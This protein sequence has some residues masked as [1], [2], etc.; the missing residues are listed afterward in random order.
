MR[1]LLTRVGLAGVALFLF[2]GRVPA[3]LLVSGSVLTAAGQRPE[4]AI[5]ELFPILS[6]FELG[7]LRLQGME[8][9]E[10]TAIGRPTRE[11]RFQ[12]EAPRSGLYRLV[13][14]MPDSMPVQIGPIALVEDLEL[15]PVAPP[16]DIGVRL[17]VVDAEGLPVA[18]ARA[19]SSGDESAENGWRLDFRLGRTGS[20]GHLT[21]PRRP[22]EK[23]SLSV[24]APAWGE[25]RLNSFAGGQVRMPPAGAL[26]RLRVVSENGAPVPGILLR[27]GVHGWPVGLSDANGVLSL[28]PSTGKPE[29]LVLVTPDGLQHRFPT[30][31]GASEDVEVV[32][33]WPAGVVLGR[34]VDARTGRPIAGA[35]AWSARDLGSFV[36][37]D[38]N[39]YYRLAASAHEESTIEVAAAGYLKARI[40]VP[41][42]QAR[43]GRAPTLGLE[44]AAILSGVITGRGRP[45]IGAIVEAVNHAARGEREFDPRASVADRA[46]TDTHGQF[47][48]RRLKGGQRYEL[49]AW[50][51]GYFPTATETTTLRPP[52]PSGPVRL[53]LAPIRALSGQVQ[54]PQGHAL[55]G[56]EVDI[57]PTI[58]VGRT[59][60]TLRLVNPEERAGKPLRTDAQGRF[61]LTAPPAMAID[62][63]FRKSGYAP[64]YLRRVGILPGDRPFN[65]G[66]VVLHPGVAI[67][68]RVI[69]KA[70]RAVAQ[71][72][73]FLLE[74]E[75]RTSRIPSL[76]NRPQSTTSR[77][78]AFAFRDLPVAVPLHLFIRAQDYQTAVVRG[79]RPPVEQPLV[80]TLEPSLS[81]RGRVM[82]EGR[83]P[84]AG[85]V[86]EAT[87]QPTLADDPQRHPTGIP[88]S[89]HATTLRS[90]S[91]EIKGL[92]RGL[93]TLSATARGF[94]G[95]ESPGLEVPLPDDTSEI[96]IV[97]KRGTLLTGRVMTTAGESVSGAHVRVGD[98]GGVSDQEGRYLIEGAPAG[99]QRVSVFHPHYP[100][101]EINHHL[102]PGLN[103]LDLHLVAGVAVSGRVVDERGQPVS[104]A[105]VALRSTDRRE[106]TA[107][108]TIDGGFF[109][110][111]V[112]RARYR[113]E[114]ERE[115]YAA[116]AATG[117][118]VVEQEPVA[119]L[120]V[121]LRE[122][123]TITGL[124]LGLEP[125]E[126]S[127]VEV[128]A[129]LMQGPVRHAVVEAQGRYRLSNLEPGDWTI[130]ASLWQGERRVTVRQPIHSEDRVI[131]RDLEFRHRLRLAGRVLLDEEPLTNARISLRGR[132]FSSERSC[133][134]GF[135][136]GFL[137]DDLEPDTYEIG[138]SE[139]TQLLA[140]NRILELT[141]D[142]EI[143]I[144]LQPT[145]FRGRV[146][147]ASS[148]TPLPGAHVT[149]HHL[150]TPEAPE[151][152]ISG[153]T[154]P[155]G[156][157]TLRQ[158]GPGTY[159]L[160]ATADGYARV[161]QLVVIEDGIKP[162][163]IEVRLEPTLGL[164]LK[165]HLSDGSPPL[166]VHL[167]ARDAAGRIGTAATL[168][169]DSTGRVKLS[170]LAEGRWT[171]LVSADNAAAA[172]IE[173][174]VPG[175]PVALAL[176][177][178]G[179]MQIRI[180]SLVISGRSATLHLFS[181]AGQPL[182]TLEPGGSLRSEWTLFA[183]QTTVAGLPEGLVIV[184]VGASDGRRWNGSA[185]VVAG[186][187]VAAILE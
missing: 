48:L 183:G 150:P 32:A 139:T 11:G 54:D 61:L 170:I 67:R 58:R 56:V 101:L 14:R 124:V 174:Q 27:Y 13:V 60:A 74:E 129:T 181:A 121:T 153:Y 78:G 159:Q 145:A 59:P 111:T 165:V 107:L 136:G 63:I 64:L 2:A 51:E 6:V 76:T 178:A 5:V 177:A 110:P 105:R 62:L 22:G 130:H 8:R 116:S 95:E 34:I 73:V 92:P 41:S 37:T 155:D 68:G 94:I 172:A 112:A 7:R 173:A 46:S 35:L 106:Y 169:V 180:P 43:L 156:A 31:S 12:L 29:E 24:F 103:T 88:V 117:E 23:L 86:V 85:A 179:R 70:G 119:G 9:L 49:R 104:G 90:G 147:S 25:V 115:G 47:R 125:D 42:I 21:L 127:R 175:P 140:H 143:E 19:F 98:A 18:G 93:V 66:R 151:F 26:R 96:E 17:E 72:D 160:E 164:E 100:R 122:G 185:T 102:G 128:E 57:Q 146:I 33:R 28:P 114:A 144:R 44:R 38:E 126:L 120:E 91:F 134:S 3:G 30:P 79:V 39:G 82:D 161:E 108:S 99:L 20:D 152:L 53:E 69:D 184:D 71:A 137:L 123:A 142:R 80:V 10:P 113:F 50:Q 4:A 55:G 36:A 132:R 75:P 149:L 186:Q 141:E 168:P 45:I 135:D 171:L 40:E 162:P 77:D 109:F 97:L 148:G 89:F 15:A 52:T 131:E 87:W 84:I 81:L 83:S 138:V 16:P 182:W 65:L 167:L 118:V 157:F 176:P 158:V 1:A 163:E 154:E 133:F 187:E 166:V